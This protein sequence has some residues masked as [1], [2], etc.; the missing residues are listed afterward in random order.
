MQNN[1]AT[2]L[3]GINPPQYNAQHALPIH[4]YNNKNVRL[5]WEDATYVRAIG[6]YVQHSVDPNVIFTSVKSRVND[7]VGGVPMQRTI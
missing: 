5:G 2:M 1:V 4:Q 7:V 3:A 6:G